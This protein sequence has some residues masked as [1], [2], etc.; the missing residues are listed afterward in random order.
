MATCPLLGD[1]RARHI[2]KIKPRAEQVSW[3]LEGSLLW[4]CL[5]A[6]W[7]SRVPFSHHEL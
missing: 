3:V 7:S 2:A 5:T 6:S 4:K 1:E